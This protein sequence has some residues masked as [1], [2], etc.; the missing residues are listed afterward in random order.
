MN[1][2]HY[3]SYSRNA[4][5]R[6]QNV[7][8]SLKIFHFQ[9]KFP[10]YNNLFYKSFDLKMEAAASYERLIYSYGTTLITSHSKVNITFCVIVLYNNS[11]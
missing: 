5:T 3:S 8:N 6:F 11:L 10:N 1:Q 9:I 4:V 2:Y 7:R